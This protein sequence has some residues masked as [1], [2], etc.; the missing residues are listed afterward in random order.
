MQNKVKL[1]TGVC[2][3]VGRALIKQFKNDE[4]ISLD[5]DSFN[6]VTKISK[7]IGKIIIKEDI[8]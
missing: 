7:N 1:I 3:E 8:L 4:V 6:A 2:G 5:L